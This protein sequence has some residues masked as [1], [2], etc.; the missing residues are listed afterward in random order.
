MVLFLLLLLWLFAFMLE[1]PAAFVR[2]KEE[3]G[4]VRCVKLDDITETSNE[5]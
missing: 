2:R 1:S 4:R 5:K 3:L